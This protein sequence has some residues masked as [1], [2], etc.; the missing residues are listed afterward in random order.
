[1]DQ[2]NKCYFT[3]N[4]NL[5]DWVLICNSSCGKIDSVNSVAPPT[6]K[7]KKVRN[8]QQMATHCLQCQ[9]KLDGNTNPVVNITE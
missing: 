4:V 8:F 6:S 1:M 9:F 2:F 7:S 3:V 5:N